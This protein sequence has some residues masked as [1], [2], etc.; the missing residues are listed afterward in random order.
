MIPTIL[1]DSTHYDY[2]NNLFV[3]HRTRD[4]VAGEARVKSKNTYYLPMPSAMLL[5]TPASSAQTFIDQTNRDKGS[6]AIYNPNYHPV[7]AYAAYLARA[8]FPEITQFIL[9]GLLGLVGAD[10][11]TITLPERLSYLKDNCTPSG[12]SLAEFYIFAISEVMVTGRLPVV[13]DIGDDGKPYMV[14]YTAEALQDWKSSALSS[15][16]TAVSSALFRDNEYGAEDIFGAEPVEIKRL[17]TI[18][19]GTYEVATYK[20]EKLRVSSAPSYQGRTLTYIPM[21]CIGSISNTFDVDPSPLSPIAAASIQI[22]MKNADLSNAEFLTCN[23]TLVLSGVEKNATPTAIGSSVCWILPDPDSKAEYTKTDT[24]ALSHVLDH[25]NQIYEHAIYQGAQLLDSSKKASESAETTRLK[26]AASG[27]T[28]LAVVNNVTNGIIKLLDMA[29]D[30]TNC[31]DSEIVFLPLTEF[32]SP[33]LSAPEHK[34]I[35]ESWVAGAISHQTL[36]ENFR[37]AG[38]LKTGDTVDEEMTRVEKESAEKEEKFLTQQAKLLG[39]KNDTTSPTQTD[40]SRNTQKTTT[41]KSGQD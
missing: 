2:K 17:A 7:P 37:K 18:S 24:S 1:K 29:A 35:V 11:P 31:K 8:E 13:L 41:D 34:A 19:S 10:V 27:A 3:W 25:I 30:W 5:T 9:R 14:P 6:S 39:A 15:D 4:C 33:T 12:L 38:L 22:Y 16:L 40:K 26:Q 36:L 20:E 28:L 23:P 21:V 32:M